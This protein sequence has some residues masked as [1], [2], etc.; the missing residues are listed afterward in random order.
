MDVKVLMVFCYEFTLI[1][2]V[3]VYCKIFF[4]T[5]FLKE[6]L[7]ITPKVKLN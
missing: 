7:K 4:S 2:F 3:L 1:I 6:L 5:V